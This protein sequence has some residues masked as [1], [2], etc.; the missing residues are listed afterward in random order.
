[1][2]ETIRAAGALSLLAALWGIAVPVAAQTVYRCGG[3]YS[4]EP[5]PG[6][7]IVSA[8][9][10]RNPEQ[11]AQT[12]AATL[13]DARTARLME[14]ARLKTE[15][16]PAQTF[17]APTR[18]ESSSVDP[19]TVG[20]LRKPELFTAIAPKKLGDAQAKGNKK[21]SSRKAAA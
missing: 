8:A 11:Q 18:F 9:D 6:A 13:R 12:E 16:Q 2:I 4:D 5:C 21:K 14:Q 10:P 20:K 19:K 17:L 7:T 3:S 1:M 15:R